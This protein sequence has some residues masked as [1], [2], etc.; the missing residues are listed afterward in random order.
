[1]QN[2]WPS[3]QMPRRAPCSYGLAC[4]EKQKFQKSQAIFT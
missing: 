2:L 4:Y 3:F 1:M